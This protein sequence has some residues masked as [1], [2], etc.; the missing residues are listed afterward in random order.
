MEELARNLHK[1]HLASSFSEAMERA[2]EIL[3][4]ADNHEQLTGTVAEAAEVVDK[5]EFLHEASNTGKKRY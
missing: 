3:R 4:H 1:L 5:A 2:E